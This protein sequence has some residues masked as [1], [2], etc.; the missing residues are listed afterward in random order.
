MGSFEV[1]VSLFKRGKACLVVLGFTCSLSAS[2]AAPE[3]LPAQVLVVTESDGEL[4]CTPQKTG[5]AAPPAG[6]GSM[7][8]DVSKTVQGLDES[9]VRLLLARNEKGEGAQAAPDP[10]ETEDAFRYTLQ[11]G[12]L[13]QKTF[14][15]VLEVSVEKDGETSTQTVICGEVDAF[16]ANEAAPAGAGGSPPKAKDARAALLPGDA[17]AVVWWRKSGAAQRRALEKAGTGLGLPDDTLFL[18]HLPSGN[19]A[20]PSPDSVREGTRLQTAIIVPAKDQ[21]EITLTRRGCAPR[22]T[23]RVRPGD[24]TDKQAGTA[25][26]GTAKDFILL[27]LGPHFECG[28][29]ELSYDLTFS[30]GD[31]STTTTSEVRVRPV[32]HLAATLLLGYDFAFR[33]SFDVDTTTDETGVATRTIVQ[34]GDREGPVAYVGALWSV[35]GVDY[36]DMDWHNYFGNLFLAVDPT[37]PTQDFAL[38]MAF[39]YTGGISLAIGATVHR[40][41]ELNGVQVGQALPGEGAVPTRGTWDNFEPG[42][43][44]GLSID[45]NIAD[46]IR[47]AFSAPSK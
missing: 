16:A 3:V 45:T 27:P 28:A 8:V 11:K 18:V 44:V 21:R 17:P 5:I 36:E 7:V 41:T 31:V 13:V 33:R 10:T 35:G 12:D 14:F 37:S 4:A 22:E 9:E 47:S 42:V 32:H 1:G 30:S 43:I 46:A 2:A 40:G 15:P 39:T 34:R 20:F 26:A 23:F 24:E 29:G 25:P 38:G 6:A 19:P